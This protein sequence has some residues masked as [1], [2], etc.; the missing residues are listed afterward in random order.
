M[1]ILDTFTKLFQTNSNNIKKSKEIKTI[2]LK[3]TEEEIHDPE[4]KKRLSETIKQLNEDKNKTIKAYNDLLNDLIKQKKKMTFQTK[5]S[6]EKT[7]VNSRDSKKTLAKSKDSQKTLAK[8][9]KKIV[10]K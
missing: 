5:K 10:F 1:N 9:L 2:I 8:S 4:L 7:L 3:S 6:S